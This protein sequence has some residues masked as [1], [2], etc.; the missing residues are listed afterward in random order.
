MR[1]VDEKMERFA[2]QARGVYRAAELVILEGPPSVVEALYGVVHAAS[3]LAEVVR[4]MVRDAHAEDTS[5]KA[6]D[7]ALAAERE[8]LL[9]QAVKGLRAAAADV[10]GDSGIRLY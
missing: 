8:H 4:R 1:D 10:L 9:H 6:E 2:V 3:D 5:P 7:T